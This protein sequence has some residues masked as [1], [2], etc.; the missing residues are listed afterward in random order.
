MTISTI[1]MSCRINRL[2]LDLSREH[3]LMAEKRVAIPVYDT[4][5]RQYRMSRLPRPSNHFAL[6]REPCRGWS[7]VS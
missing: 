5:S 3:E 7:S 1:Q 4:R 6:V 2:V